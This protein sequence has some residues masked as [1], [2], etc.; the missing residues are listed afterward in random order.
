MFLFDKITI[1]NFE[2]FKFLPNKYTD[3]KTSLEEPK[4]D[5]F[6]CNLLLNFPY[7]GNYIIQVDLYIVDNSDIVWHHSAERHQIL[8]KVEEDPARQKLFA[9][10]AA[11]AAASATNAV[12]TTNGL[13]IPQSF[14]PQPGSIQQR[15]IHPYDMAESIESTQKME[16]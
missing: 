10:L 6:N 12:V 1:L 8:V 11:A 5:Y 2:H 16:N 3:I 9:A 4:N 14:Q 13:N 15:T 7:C